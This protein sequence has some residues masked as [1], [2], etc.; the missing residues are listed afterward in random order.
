[1][2]TQEQ[3]TEALEQ[4]KQIVESIDMEQVDAELEQHLSNTHYNIQIGITKTG[5]KTH[6]IYANRPWCAIDGGWNT[7]RSNIIKSMQV[8]YS[9][10][11]NTIENM[12]MCKKCMCGIQRVINHYA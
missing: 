10:I 2:V 7:G 6:M 4:V 12:D 1:M 8:E 11:E 9:E 3:I 5:T